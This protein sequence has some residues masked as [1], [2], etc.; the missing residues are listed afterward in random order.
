MR[1]PILRWVLLAVLLTAM[2]MIGIA[3]IVLSALGRDISPAVQGS[4]SCPSPAATFSER[5][6]TAMPATTHKTALP[7]LD[8]E[9]PSH[10]E[11]A[12]FG[13]G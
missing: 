8:T 4:A 10:L 5:K 2:N 3:G 12:T 1:T 13:L 9:I 7:L 6:K 11:T